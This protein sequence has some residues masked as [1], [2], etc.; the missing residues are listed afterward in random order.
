MINRL[1]E[2][3]RRDLTQTLRNRTHVQNQSRD[4]VVY[5]AFTLYQPFADPGE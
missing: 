2:E 1:C 3:L 4:S 5:F